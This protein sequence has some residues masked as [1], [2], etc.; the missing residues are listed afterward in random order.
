MGN[1]Q[2]TPGDD[3]FTQ[4]VAEG[5]ENDSVRLLQQVLA[6]DPAIYPEA[7]VT[8]YFGGLTTTALSRFQQTWGLQVTGTFTPETRFVLATVLEARPIGTNT[9]DYLQQP[10]V[11]AEITAAI[12]S[13]G[14]EPTIRNGRIVF[15][16]NPD[17]SFGARNSD[18][19]T[20][21]RILATDPA[22]YPEATIT[23]THERT[24]A[25]AVIRFQTRYGIAITGQVDAATLDVLEALL[26]LNNSSTIRPDL[27][28]MAAAAADR[29]V[30]NSSRDI[31]FVNVVRNQNTNEVSVTVT[32]EGG[33]TERF[34][35]PASSAR[36]DSAAEAAIASR[37]GRERSEISST[38]TVSTVEAAE[39]P[40]RI[41]FYLSRQDELTGSIYF[42]DY[43][44][45][46][47]DV[48]DEEVDFSVPVFIGG[49]LVSLEVILDDFKQKLRSGNYTKEELDEEI[50]EIIAE[51][52]GV[53]INQARSVDLS[54]VV[55]SNSND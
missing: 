2:A 18:V 14:L 38:I 36:T 52:Y 17:F 6:S 19:A 44:F 7:R 50:H 51:M 41:V 26:V 47:S 32:Y 45:D 12:N 54:Y 46:S 43:D 8:G 39:L 1:V 10:E 31:L 15:S 48:G 16:A 25:E 9:E 29:L 5:S 28:R 35:L 55:E 24:T 27:L 11:R 23:A 21:Q 33:V 34:T 20:M 30:P 13:Y 49:Q 53:S 40:R 37:L 22:I 3:V 4:P 42:S